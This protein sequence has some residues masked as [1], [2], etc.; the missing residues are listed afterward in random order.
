MNENI[1]EAEE[2]ELDTGLCVCKDGPTLAIL[3]DV[4]RMYEEKMDL[5]E[6]IG[7][8]KKLQVN[9]HYIEYRNRLR[10]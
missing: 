2:A 5:I 10:S 4:Q 7:G 6:R 1:V 9:V 3:K 8:S